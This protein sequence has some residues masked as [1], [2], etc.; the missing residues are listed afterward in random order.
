[1]A[2]PLSSESARTTPQCVRVACGTC[3]H[4]G[5]PGRETVKNESSRAMLSIF[6]AKTRMGWKETVVSE[7]ANADGKPFIFGV[8]KND[9]TVCARC[10]RHMFSHG[11]PRA[12]DGQERVVARNAVDLFCEDPDGL[13]RVGRE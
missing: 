2:S 1:M 7:H 12:G 9:A 10:V 4:T 13:E 6:F 3:F 5:T 11:N 8:S